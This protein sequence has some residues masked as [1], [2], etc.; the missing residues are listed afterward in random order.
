[1]TERICSLAGCEAPVA[2]GRSKYCSDEHRKEAARRA[3][4]AR[5]AEE[6][7]GYDVD[8]IVKRQLERDQNT[9]AAKTLRELARSKAKREEYIDAIKEVLAPFE[10]SQPLPIF[11]PPTGKEAEVKWAIVYSDWQLG[12]KTPIESTGGIFEQDTA[13]VRQQLERMWAAER[14]IHA[15]EI[16]SGAKR[17]NT[18]WHPVLGDIVDG[19]ALRPSQAAAIDMV[20][21]RQVVEAFDLL[22]QQIQRELKYLPVDKIVI[23][24]VGGNHDRTSTKAGNAALGELDFVDT[25]AFLLGAMLQRVFADEPRVEIQNWETF[26]G[27][28]IF[29]GLRHVFEHGASF[30]GSS[31]S[32]GGVP[33]YPIVNAANNYRVM[34]DGADVVMMGHFHKPA[35][36]PYGKD[37]WQIINGA[38]PPSS[39]FIQAAFK[40]V[41]KPM[42]WL[43]EYHAD[44]GITQFQPLY[45]DISEPV[46]VWERA[47]ND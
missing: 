29:A 36:L 46:N 42:Q 19:D 3:H 1:M 47:K 8:G 20:V 27:Y 5:R 9:A 6:E 23:D 33:W 21:T 12:Q 10:P 39:Q 7:L 13:I 17:L 35:V 45:A 2:T 28:R 43:L 15:V 26:F 32:Y 18:L 40:G 38:L 34:L 25:Y 16:G 22:Q 31:A 41:R 11:T 44:H 4:E 14:S 24:M 37:G 30:K